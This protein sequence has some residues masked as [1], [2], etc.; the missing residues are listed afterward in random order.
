MAFTVVTTTGQA[1]ASLGTAS[2]VDATIS[3]SCR[4]D[5]TTRLHEK[6]PATAVSAVS[7]FMISEV[8][9][10]MSDKTYGTIT[11]TAG[12]G[13]PTASISGGLYHSEDGG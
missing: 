10:N 3:I 9:Y 13:T 5:R 12:S 2:H 6:V 1:G 11:V 4:F 7:N 8:A